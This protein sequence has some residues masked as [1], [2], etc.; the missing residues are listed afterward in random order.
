MD[1]L[2]RV[3]RVNI[4]FQQPLDRQKIP[5][6]HVGPMPVLHVQHLKLMNECSPLIEH[7]DADDYN[8]NGLLYSQ[9]RLS[10]LELVPA[11]PDARRR[12]TMYPVVLAIFSMIPDHYQ[13][14]QIQEE[15]LS[16]I[17]RWEL[18]N[19]EISLH[20][21]FEQLSSQKSNAVSNA[22]LSVGT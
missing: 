20:K 7:G 6:T 11:G 8:S 18:R 3:Y 19:A 15:P 12:D 9:A 10:H 1:K 2:L 21:S 16:I 13:N 17:S 22:D 14:T 4:D 5:P